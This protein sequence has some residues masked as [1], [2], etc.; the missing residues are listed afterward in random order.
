MIVYLDLFA[1]FL[2][3]LLISVRNYTNL[4]VYRMGAFVLL[5]QFLLLGFFPVVFLYPAVFDFN[6]TLG[7]FDFFRGKPFI[8]FLGMPEG[9]PGLFIIRV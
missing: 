7:F 5:F 4:E 8:V 3:P 1:E 6:K 2:K 9:F